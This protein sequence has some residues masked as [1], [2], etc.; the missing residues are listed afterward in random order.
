[1]FVIHEDYNNF[2]IAM[3]VNRADID[4]LIDGELSLEEERRVLLAIDQNPA[5]KKYYKTML[6]QKSL[7]QDWWTQMGKTQN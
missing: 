7:L 3:Y 5:M 4:A 2:D 1:M 6:V